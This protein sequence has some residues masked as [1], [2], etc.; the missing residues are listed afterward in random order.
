MSR[1]IVGARSRLQDLVVAIICWGFLLLL[2]FLFC[3]FTFEHLKGST[4]E[5]PCNSA[6]TIL[7]SII[8]WYLEIRDTQGTVQNCPA[9]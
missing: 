5:W 8:Q 9:F 3:F 2:L 7:I 6:Y 1:K 4:Y